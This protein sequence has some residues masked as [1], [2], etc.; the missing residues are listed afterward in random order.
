MLKFFLNWDIIL[1]PL[2]SLTL[3]SSARSI[4]P[5]KGRPLLKGSHNG[6]SKVIYSFNADEEQRDGKD[7][8]EEMRVDE[9]GYELRG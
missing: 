9:N 2:F 7:C 3:E 8:E 1:H 6:V 5:C 4:L